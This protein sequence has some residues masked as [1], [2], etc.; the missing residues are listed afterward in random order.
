MKQDSVPE[1]ERPILKQ[2]YDFKNNIIKIKKQNTLTLDDINK[3]CDALAKHLE[4]LRQIRT[5][6]I[7][8]GDRNRLDDVIDAIWLMMFEIWAPIAQIDQHLYPTY[9][10]LA[11]MQRQLETFKLTGSYTESDLTS[12]RS[13]LQVLEYW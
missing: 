10:Q 13:H 2:L 11:G 7:N 5:V 12:I 4:T 8:Y 9:V 1:V 3:Q 6:N